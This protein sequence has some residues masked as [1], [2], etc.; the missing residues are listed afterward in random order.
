M[1]PPQPTPP[2]I[3]AVADGH[4]SPLYIRS[5][6]GAR[7]AVHA[8]ITLLRRFATSHADQPTLSAIKRVAADRLPRDL[9]MTWGEA[10]A[11]DLAAEPLSRRELD[12]L[13]RHVSPAAL[14]RLNANPQL[15]YGS[16]L[17]A[18]LI[19]DTYLLTF[20]LGDGDILLVAEDGAAAPITLAADP[21]LFANETTSLCSPK[22]WRHAR[23]YLQPAPA[24][25]PPLL[26]LATD[27]YANS[28]A[29]RAGFLQAGSDLLAA[30]RADGLPALGRQL[31]AWLRD[32]SAAGSGDDITL[33]LAYRCAPGKS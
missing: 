1:R 20:Q 31:P 11:A 30:L 16:T 28:F 29:D 24:A 33:A 19:T 14:A 23:T 7:T 4:G 21:L 25:S 3:L 26:I 10:V 27:G 8:A 17:L 32:T 6:R 13:A 15:A 12:A 9:V 22:A 2:I 5:G 18:A